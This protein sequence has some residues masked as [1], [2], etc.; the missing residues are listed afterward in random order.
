MFNDRLAVPF[1][2][3]F[4][5]PTLLP[6]ERKFTVPVGVPLP[7]AAA[8]VTVS[9]TFVA[10]LG[11]GGAATGRLVV[12]LPSEAGW[13]AVAP[14]VPD[15]YRICPVGA[16]VPGAALDTRKMYIFSLLSEV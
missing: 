13:A 16:L 3:S 2:L 11:D 5:E 1:L 8:T 14:K 9:V 6:S 15:P 7:S 10:A 12:V 4:A